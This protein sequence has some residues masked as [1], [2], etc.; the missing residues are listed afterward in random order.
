M[1]APSTPTDQIMRGGN[2]AFHE[3]APSIKS[4]HYNAKR[5]GR[6]AEEAFRLLKERIELIT[7]AQYQKLEDEIF[8]TR[9]DAV[10]ALDENEFLGCKREIE[11][12]IRLLLSIMQ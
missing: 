4:E 9:I 11:A 6:L 5:I 7:P 1:S 12:I 10:N 8:Y 3:R 2:G